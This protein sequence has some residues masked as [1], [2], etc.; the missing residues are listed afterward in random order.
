[1]TRTMPLI[2]DKTALLNELLPTGTLRFGVVFAPAVSTFFVAMN[3]AQEPWGP[4][5]DI[6]RELAR[7]LDVPVEFFVVPNSGELV[8]ALERGAIDVT[9][10]P[11]DDERKQRVDFGP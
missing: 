5:V 3:A 4:A 6:C 11:V 9:C 2:S 10:V 1:M 8:D 7:T